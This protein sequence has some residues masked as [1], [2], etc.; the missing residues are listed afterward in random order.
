MAN[1]EFKNIIMNIFY[2]LYNF[3]KYYA[4]SYINNI[5]NNPIL[6]LIITVLLFFINYSY[7]SLTSYK[8]VDTFLGTLLSI[9]LIFS[10]YYLTTE[11]T[12]IINIIFNSKYYSYLTFGF[13]FLFIYI[14]FYLIDNHNPFNVISAKNSII[15]KLGAVFM[16]ILLFY[17]FT[18]RLNNSFYENKTLFETSSSNK[19][20][21][22]ANFDS[23]LKEPIKNMFSSIFFTLLSILIPILIIVLLFYAFNN[24]HQLFYATKILLLISFVIS[25]LAIIAQLININFDDDK[26]FSDLTKEKSFFIKLM[27]AIK[28]FI[29]YLPCLLYVTVKNINDDLKITPKSIYILFFL[30]LLITCILFILPMLFNYI[31]NINK[32][33]LL[34][35]K[36]IVHTNKYIKIANYQR[37]RGEK[38]NIDYKD[39]LF[40][41]NFTLFNKSEETSKNLE[42]TTN[43]KNYEKSL[44]KYSYGISFYLY[45]NPQDTNTNPAYNKEGGAE[46]F[47][48]G[49]KPVILYD[50]RTRELII[51]TKTLD[52]NNSAELKTIYKTKD[53]KYQ[54]WLYFVINYE[55]NMIDIFID[56]KLVK[57]EN[58]NSAIDTKLNIPEFNFNDKVTIGDPDYKD[59]GIHG[60]IKDI[61]YYNNIIPID[62]IEFIFDLNKN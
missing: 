33:N 32:N 31:V 17:F 34:G 60:S 62:N 49:N 38:N 30:L 20:M 6:W 26:C 4:T 51:K 19:N 35:E 41:T 11:F 16:S 55:N 1:Y 61:Y 43:G 7:F 14:I 8:L 37:L 57:L 28:Y 39:N 2:S 24:Y 29:F 22:W 45:L 53:I 36:N 13:L 59:N 10:V 44:N 21:D 48:Y 42:I 52:N 46:I 5:S 47:N 56:G 25:I 54:K 23:S 27:C 40:Y 3:F 12:K 18:Y 9:I 15:L 58:S 50:G